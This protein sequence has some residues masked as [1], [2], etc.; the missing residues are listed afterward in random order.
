M[1]AEEG[2]DMKGRTR[3]HA[4]FAAVMP[5]VLTTALAGSAAAQSDEV[6]EVLAPGVM[7]SDW[8]VLDRETGTWSPTEDHP[9]TWEAVL[10]PAPEPY[11]LAWGSQSETIAFGVDVSRGV[12]EAAALAGIELNSLNNDWPDTAKPI[13]LAET[14]ALTRPDLFINFNAIVG[15]YPRIQQIVGE[16]GVPTITI[17]FQVPDTPVFGADNFTVGQLAGA[18]LAR[19]ILD[20][21]WEQEGVHVVG[22]DDLRLGA[23]IRSRIDGF[24]FALNRDTPL[25]P[26]DQ[27]TRLDCQDPEGSQRL[28]T[29]WLT[30]N[31]DAQHIVMTGISDFRVIAMA[32]AVKAAGRD[33]QAAGVGLGLDESAKEIIRRGDPPAF[34]GSVAFYPEL[35]GRYAIAMALDGLEGKPVPRSVSPHHI[36][37]DANNIDEHYPLAE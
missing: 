37:V 9:A 26:V 12:Q 32:N 4:A 30:A 31:P 10:R 2:C 28:M 13:E 8:L 1:S 24:F 25:I 18:Y 33:E 29:D 17:T 23:F 36:V 6:I 3:R 22:C 34:R 7:S 5:L 27:Y 16:A 19:L 20:E 14:V 21:G 35:Y 15:I 11:R